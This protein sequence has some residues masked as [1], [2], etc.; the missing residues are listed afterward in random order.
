MKLCWSSEPTSRPKIKYVSQYLD[1]I[2]KRAADS[3]EPPAAPDQQ[4][5]QSDQDIYDTDD[6]DMLDYGKE[7]TLSTAGQ[8]A[9]D[10]ELNRLDPEA[11]VTKRH[12]DKD[13]TESD[14]E[15]SIEVEHSWSKP[16]SEKLTT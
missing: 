7:I 16:D 3:P 11:I 14:L 9:S 13:L 10:H 5:V 15:V 1:R 2:Q 6:L 4:D 8:Q 12:V